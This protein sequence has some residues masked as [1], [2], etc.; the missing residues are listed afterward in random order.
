MSLR[1]LS[2]RFGLPPGLPTRGTVHEFLRLVLE[3]FHWLT[4]VAFGA[5]DPDRMLPA[6][7]CAD[8]LADFYESFREGRMK[9]LTVAG[10]AERDVLRV[11]PAKPGDFPH[12]GVARWSTAARVAAR[13]SW[14]AAHAEQVARLMRLLDAPVAMTARDPH[15][16]RAP[17]PTCT[18]ASV[19][20]EAGIRNNHIALHPT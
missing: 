20:A 10:T 9:A 11:L 7:G 5:L 12:A 16:R 4:P 17:G 13:S 18:C 14:R 15:Q 6:G 3:E 1:L 8:T 2:T 19:S